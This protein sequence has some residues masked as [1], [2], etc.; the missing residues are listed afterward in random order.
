MRSPAGEK[1]PAGFP[2][3]KRG[4]KKNAGVALRSDRGLGW[5]YSRTGGQAV[6]DEKSLREIRQGL[7]ER[8]NQET[9][10]LLDTASRDRDLL[11]CRKR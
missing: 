7:E 10:T 1:K 4:A 8:L 2:V 6:F 5:D 3:Y 9:N 11:A